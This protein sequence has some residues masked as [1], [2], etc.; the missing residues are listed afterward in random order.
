MSIPIHTY[1]VF[2]FALVKVKVC[3]VGAAT[4]E[5]AIAQA[6]AVV[7]ER[8]AELF[9]EEFTPTGAGSEIEYVEGA[10]ENAYFLADQ[11]A[12]DGETVRSDWFSGAMTLDGAPSAYPEAV[13]PVTAAPTTQLV[14]PKQ[15]MRLLKR[16]SGSA[17]GKYSS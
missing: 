6:K 7:P 14:S 3:R 11:L 5:D 2:V 10:E 1:D 9:R 17:T 12:N 8:G 16:D 15:P 4:P 13:L